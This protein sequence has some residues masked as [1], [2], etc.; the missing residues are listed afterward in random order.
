MRTCVGEPDGPRCGDFISLQL[1]AP[2]RLTTRRI[3]REQI[4]AHRRKCVRTMVCYVRVS[5]VSS[6]RRV[7]L[8]L[9]ARG[10]W[11]GSLHCLTRSTGPARA[12]LTCTRVCAVSA[13]HAPPHTRIDRLG[14]AVGSR[15]PRNAR[16]RQRPPA[17]H[18][19][20]REDQ[21]AD[22][23]TTR[24]KGHVSTRQVSTQTRCECARVTVAGTV[25]NS[26]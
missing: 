7:V 4:S 15:Q 13:V 12:P 14:R 10:R 8:C 16:S 6:V 26:E 11:C 21:L 20:S 5:C 2:Q 18:D 1:I 22:H 3:A 24:F 23:R 25:V 19:G 9:C 17:F